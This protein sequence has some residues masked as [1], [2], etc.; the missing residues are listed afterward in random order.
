MKDAEGLLTADPL[1]VLQAERDRLGGLWCGNMTPA[2]Q[3]ELDP[4]R[5]GQPLKELTFEVDGVEREIGWLVGLGL[6]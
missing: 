4:W 3:G 2:Q 6:G 5:G 1:R